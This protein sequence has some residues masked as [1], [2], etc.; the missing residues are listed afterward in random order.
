MKLFK[1]GAEEH[2]VHLAVCKSRKHVVHANH[3]QT[4]GSILIDYRANKSG[5][6][7]RILLAHGCQRSAEDLVL[8]SRD[9]QFQLIHYLPGQGWRKLFAQHRENYLVARKKNVLDSFLLD[10]SLQL[11]N[12]FLAVAKMKILHRSLIPAQSPASELRPAPDL[13]A[14]HRLRAEGTPEAENENARRVRI[15]DDGGIRAILVL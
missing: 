3:G 8:R 2:G 9:V 13:L 11:L 12:D 6:R 5:I 4:S 14:N 7:L 1:P 10:D 15:R